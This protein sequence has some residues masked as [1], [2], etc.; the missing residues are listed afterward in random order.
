[1]S[2]FFR[3]AF[4]IFIAG[5]QFPSMPHFLLESAD[6]ARIVRRPQTFDIVPNLRSVVGV[7]V[8]R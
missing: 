8:G 6:I 4:Q 2:D 3:S 7:F 5:I 1:V